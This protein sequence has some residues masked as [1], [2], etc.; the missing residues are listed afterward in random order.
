MADSAPCR[1]SMLLS[2][3]L[4]AFV[5]SFDQMDCDCQCDGHEEDEPCTS[6]CTQC[7]WCLAADLEVAWNQEGEA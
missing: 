4:W 3:R 2:E 6:S 7:D 1:P 5:T